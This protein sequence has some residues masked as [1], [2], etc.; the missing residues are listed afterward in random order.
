VLLLLAERTEQVFHQ[1]PVQESTVF[2]GPGALQ[3]GKL[4]Y[5]GN[6]MFRGGDGSL[7]LIQIDKDLNLITDSHV[8][9][10]VTIGQ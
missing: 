10:H 6:R 5:L 8:G 3:P 1:S 7:V 4:A 9:H 2:I